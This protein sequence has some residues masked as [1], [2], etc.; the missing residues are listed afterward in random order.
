MVRTEIL[1]AA[2]RAQAELA[3]AIGATQ[4]AGVECPDSEEA[5]RTHVSHVSLLR[6][7]IKEV[8]VAISNGPANA[9]KRIK[10]LR[11]T[12]VPAME[13]TRTASDLLERDMAADCWPM[14]TY[15]EM[16]LIKH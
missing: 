2:M 9:E 14:P 7:A 1:P 11:E 8:E 10:H 4:V 5:L 15:V 13:K 16:L 12:L 6:Q 3:D